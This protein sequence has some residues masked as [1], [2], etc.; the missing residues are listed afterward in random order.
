MT[1]GPA[2]QNTEDMATKLAATDSNTIYALKDPKVVS[3]RL[4][5]ASTVMTMDVY[6][7]VLPDMQEAAT[8]KLEAMLYG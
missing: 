6:C 8:Q 4:G 2:E 7:H 3:E 1:V 5:H